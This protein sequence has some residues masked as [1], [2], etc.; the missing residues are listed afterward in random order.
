MPVQ[1]L[2]T[3]HALADFN[4]LLAAMD[5]ESGDMAIA[6]GILDL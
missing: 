3:G 2:L 6:L 4:H 1:N 5:V